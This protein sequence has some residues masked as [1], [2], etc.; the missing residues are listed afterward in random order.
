MDKTVRLI[1]NSQDSITDEKKIH[2]YI[3]RSDFYI[4]VSRPISRVLFPAMQGNDHLSWTAVTG[5]L[6]RPT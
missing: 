2:F 4:F 6:Q 1:E 3:S 5:S